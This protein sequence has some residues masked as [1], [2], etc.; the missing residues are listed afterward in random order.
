M[1]QRSITHLQPIGTV[2]MFA[3]ST[4][5]TGWL[6]C[7]G[8]AISRTSY[9]DL[10]SVIGT[11]YGT[12]DGSTTFNLPDF[13]GRFLRSWDDGRG[14]DSGRTFASLQ[15]EQNGHDHAIGSYGNN[16]GSW[17]AIDYVRSYNNPNNKTSYHGLNSYAWGGA[18][19]DPGFF[20]LCTT[21]PGNSSGVL[22]PRNVALLYCIKY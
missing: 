15:T 19:S 21:G 22:R 7:N 16:N 2:S 5:P 8:A 18:F 9:S 1:Q 13:R 12:G 6:K 20:Y 17:L 3:N 14:V 11:T 10:F 4:A